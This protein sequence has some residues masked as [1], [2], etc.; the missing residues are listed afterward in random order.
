M[1]SCPNGKKY[2][3]ITCQSPNKRWLS[4]G[5]GYSHNEHFF[6]A[7]VK[8]GWDNISH[9]I[10]FDGLTKEE[11]C[12]REIKLIAKYQS[13]NPDFGYNLSSGG[14]NSGSGVHHARSEEAKKKQ[15]IAM[16]GRKASDETKKKMSET[17]KGKKHSKKHPSTKGH[18]Q[19]PHTD[20]QK[21]QLSEMFRGNKNPNY[22]KKMADEQK[23]KISESTRN[24]KSVI[25]SSLCGEVIKQ[26]PSAKQ[27]E[28]ETG[29]FNGNIIA[30]CKG[31][32][33]TMGGYKWSYAS[34][35]SSKR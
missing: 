13:N 12:K 31:K 2:I 24:K 32:K 19:P 4:D 23:A 30:C 11:A 15:S 29:I 6:R 33:P 34:G 18:F 9:D 10:M 3:G 21:R 17:R 20:E 16:T 26:Y 7:I 25:Q 1:H 8:Y 5:S 28:R 14:E 22:G 27:A 35:I